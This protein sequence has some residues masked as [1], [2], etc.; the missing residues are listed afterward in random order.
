[1][2]LKANVTYGAKCSQDFNSD[3]FSLTLESEVDPGHMQEEVADLFQQAKDAVQ[4]QIDRGGVAKSAHPTPSR[5]DSG[6]PVNR[7]RRETGYGNGRRNGNGGNGSNG[8]NGRCATQAQLKAV[9]A[10]SK[11]I[12]MDESELHGILRRDFQ[13]DDVKYLSV[14]EASDLIESLKNQQANSH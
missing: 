1:M 8:G 6:A 13:S 2:G 9:Y 3:N 7:T 14:K 10:I 11:A 12:G 5:T 4:F